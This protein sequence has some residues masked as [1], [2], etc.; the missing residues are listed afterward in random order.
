MSALIMAHATHSVAPPANHYLRVA[1]DAYL[2]AQA[3]LN[4]RLAALEKFIPMAIPL[5]L[6][7]PLPPQPEP[8]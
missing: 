2:A 5:G 4:A 3:M 1:Q 6:P 7:A 8:P